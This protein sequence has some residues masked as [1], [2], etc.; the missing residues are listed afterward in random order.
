M[1]AKRSVKCIEQAEIFLA[2]ISVF[3]GGYGP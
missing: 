2:R 1:L 3:A